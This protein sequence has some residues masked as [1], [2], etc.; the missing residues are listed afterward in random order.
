MHTTAG[1]LTEKEREPVEGLVSGRLQRVTKP[2]GKETQ[3]L[4]WEEI[5]M[6]ET[7]LSFEGAQYK[8][9]V[10]VSQTLVWA[11]RGPGPGSGRSPPPPSVH[12]GTRPRSSAA[13]T[14]LPAAPARAAPSEAGPPQ[15]PRGPPSPR[16]TFRELGPQRPGLLLWAVRLPPEE[17]HHLGREAQHGRPP[18]LSA[19][20]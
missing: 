1:T 10:G 17:G 5:A 12:A 9:D 16:G 14:R 7:R 6:K 11:R 20:A 8:G 2:S 4:R 18:R 13:P 3:I 15:G 19:A